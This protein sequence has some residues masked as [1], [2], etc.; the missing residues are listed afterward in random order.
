MIIIEKKGTVPFIPLYHVR[1]RHYGR[2]LPFFELGRDE[3]P[4]AQSSPNT[5]RME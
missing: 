5:S 4:A 3:Y 2:E 1:A